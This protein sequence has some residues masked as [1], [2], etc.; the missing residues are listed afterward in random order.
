MIQ[1]LI[2]EPTVILHASCVIDDNFTMK[3]SSRKFELLPCGLEITV[4][5][6]FE[7]FDEIGD[8][9]QGHDI[10]LQDPRSCHIEV[11]YCNP[12]RL[13]ADDIHTCPPLSEV[14][15]KRSFINLQDISLRP[16]PLDILSSH[17]ELE[18]T[19]QPLVIRATLQK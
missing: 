17:T 15:P 13:S 10:Y 5:G 18:E 14:V 16:D 11:K 1:S 2:D 3:K 12:Q 8:W 6:S 7:I 19:P 4:Y 9:F